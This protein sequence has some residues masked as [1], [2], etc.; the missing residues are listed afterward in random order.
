MSLEEK[1]QNGSL[2]HTGAVNEIILNAQK[3]FKDTLR[4]WK[5]QTGIAPYGDRAVAFGLVGSADISGIMLSKK[6]GLGIRIEI[7]FKVGRDKQRESQKNFENMI[8][9][10]GGV[11]FICSNSVQAI[12]FLK[13]ARSRIER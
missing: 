6:H 7:E 4:L 11:Y 10:F 2:D 12:N 8:T 9:K 1:F 3:E 13:L 5:N